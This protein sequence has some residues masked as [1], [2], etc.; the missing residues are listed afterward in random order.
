MTFGPA[1]A[2][3]GFVRA[4]RHRLFPH[5]VAAA[6]R[7]TGLSSQELADIYAG[8]IDRWPDGTRIRL[9][10]RLMGDTDSRMIKTMSPA[11]D[12]ALSAA[13]MRKGVAFAVT[14]QDAADDLE[15]IPGALGRST[16]ARIISEKRALTALEL[17]HVAPDPAS[18][19]DG[20]YPYSKQLFMVA[21]S[22]APPAVRRFMAFVES[23]EGRDIL[24]RTGYWVP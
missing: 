23:A 9:V 7:T 13:E 2:P 16:L 17:D 12:E 15:T 3:P 5:T 18:I 14:D 10:L 24:I 22:D 4:R 11:M 1:D 6:N 8:K 21:K 20:S 19:A